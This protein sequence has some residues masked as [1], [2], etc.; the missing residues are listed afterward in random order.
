M[1]AIAG[2][3]V[4]EV[5]EDEMSRKPKPAFVADAQQRRPPVRVRRGRITA[6]SAKLYPPD[7]AERIWWDRLK[8]TLGTSSSDFVNASLHQLQAAA[9]FPGS[10]I[11]EVGINAALAFI[12][13]FAPRNEVEASLA[14]QMACTH[15][16]T[17]SVLGRLGPATGTEDHVCRF[18]SAAARLIRAY[19]VQ[20]EAYRRL[21]HGG[22]QYVRV[23]HVHINEGAQ[24]VIGN[25]HPSEGGRT[26]A[27]ET[28]MRVDK[29]QSRKEQP[30]GL[31]MGKKSVGTSTSVGEGI[32][33]VDRGLCRMRLTRDAAGNSWFTL[34]DER[35]QIV[36]EG[37]LAS[38][39]MSH[40]PDEGAA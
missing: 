27:P 11:S 5:C 21:R 26:E 6:E 16:A 34:V 10:G 12:E 4:C 24:A 30:R 1:A 33:L 14:V 9:Q 23:E 37:K 32:E 28:Q 8:K 3:V 15:G 7:G 18:A 13:S 31:E 40:G 36:A 25:V 2:A 39:D 22:D 17:M 29:E 35:G 20:L 19:T 38:A